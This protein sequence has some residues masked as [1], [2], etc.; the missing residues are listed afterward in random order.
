MGTV[1]ANQR[2]AKLLG[3]LAT[4]QSEGSPTTE[5]F[6]S[7]YRLAQQVSTPEYCRTAVQNHTGAK[8]FVVVILRKLDLIPCRLKH[9]R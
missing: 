9:E 2:A 8:E 6:A 3:Q 4:D 7:A 1:L 5:V